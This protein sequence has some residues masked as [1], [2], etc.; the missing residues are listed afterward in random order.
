MSYT[1]WARKQ[2]LVTP[3]PSPPEPEASHYEYSE[4]LL[5]T[6]DIAHLE[7]YLEFREVNYL[8]LAFLWAATQ[9]GDFYWAE[10]YE[11]ERELSED[12]VSYLEG[13]VRAYYAH[14][15]R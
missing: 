9:Q 12:D 7:N 8:D 10:I 3:L 5:R 6:V 2:G 14:L 13:L 15:T 11:E 1:L 4:A